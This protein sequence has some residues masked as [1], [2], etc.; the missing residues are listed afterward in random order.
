MLFLYKF[1]YRNLKSY[2]FLII[3]T[4]IFTFVQVG[5]EILNPVPLKFILD[6]L[7]NHRDPNF[8]GAG[9]FLNFFDQF[10]AVDHLKTGEGHTQFGIIIF[11]LASIIVLS[12]LSAA[13]FY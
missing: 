4:F 3:I 13:T 10:A 5:A 11:S 7:V 9:S 6:K 1:L 2:R 8:P 12:L